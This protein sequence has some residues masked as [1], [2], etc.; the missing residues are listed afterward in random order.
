MSSLF[1]KLRQEA[2]ALSHEEKSE[3]VYELL[4]DL[5][6]SAADPGEATREDAKYQS[7]S[8]VD[9]N[10]DERADDHDT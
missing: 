9:Q 7:G 3:L 10:V 5:Q 1:E 6:G 8:S 4:C 2:L